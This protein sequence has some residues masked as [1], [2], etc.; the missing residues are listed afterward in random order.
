MSKQVKAVFGFRLQIN[1]R[2]VKFHK[3]IKTN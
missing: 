3:Q 2:V 1:L